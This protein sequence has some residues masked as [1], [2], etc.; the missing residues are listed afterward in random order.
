LRSDTG[1]A[2]AEALAQWQHFVVMQIRDAM[3]EDAPAAC[4]VLRQSIE[5]L[6][7]ADHRNDPVILARWLSNKTPAN[8]ASWI[9][10]PDHSLFLAVEDATVLAVGAVTDA[11]E[12][13]L[14]YVAPNAR[15]RG[16]SRTLLAALEA[17]A[18]QRGNLRCTLFSTETA[19][20]F[21]R[22]RGYVDDGPPDRKYGMAGG[23]PMSKPLAVQNT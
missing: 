21:Y 13:T 1:G 2:I 20:R 5:Q 9:A 18:A 23:Y 7:D 16:A 6:C 17:R 4:Q 22:A 12:I 15:F 11:G 8:L 14:N 3:I 10:R 19:H